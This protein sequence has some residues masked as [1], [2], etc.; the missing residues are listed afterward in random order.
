MYICVPN[1]TQ[2]CDCNVSAIYDCSHRTP[3]LIK[4][5]QVYHRTAFTLL[6][7]RNVHCSSR[8]RANLQDTPLSKT[9]LFFMR[10]LQQHNELFNVYLKI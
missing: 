2:I 1:E 7:L 10:G 4:F 6:L 9:Q 8:L 5:T 3:W